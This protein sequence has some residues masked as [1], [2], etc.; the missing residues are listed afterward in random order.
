MLVSSKR[1][2]KAAHYA[3]AGIALM[4]E[5]KLLGVWPAT[6]DLSLKHERVDP[7]FRSVASVARADIESD[8]V[9]LS[10]NVDQVRLTISGN[11]TSDNLD[12]I[13]SVLTT[14]MRSS[15]IVLATPL[16][17]L[18]RVEGGTMWLPTLSYA[19]QQQHPFGAGTPADGG[20]TA[21]D[22]P[23]QLNVQQ[24]LDA[25]WQLKQLQLAYHVDQSSEDNRQPGFELADITTRTHRVTVG[26]PVGSSLRLAL[27]LGIE[28]QEFKELAQLARLR[29]AGLTGN[30]QM[31]P[32]TRLDGSITLHR[33]NDTRIGSNTHV[34]SLLLGLA[35]DIRLWHSTDGIRR[36]QLWLRFTRQANDVYD[37]ANPLSPPAQSA[38]WWRLASGL[39]LRL[40]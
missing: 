40:L 13:A 24:S 32:F 22:V 25:Q 21:S 5:Q 6:L 28:R 2:R 8:N 23:D 39:T 36:G 1:N 33:T 3:E 4:R 34:S 31:T 10:G 16:A 9:E 11:R 20:F 27:D 26:G 38:G 35:R 19:R 18:L 37:L 30:W 12:A 17:P 7:M 15:S 29:K 14:R